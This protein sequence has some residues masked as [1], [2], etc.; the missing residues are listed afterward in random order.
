MN[1]TQDPNNSTPEAQPSWLA[2]LLTDKDRFRSWIASA[3]G[4]AAQPVSSD[5]R[6][7]LTD[8]G[9]QLLEGLALPADESADTYPAVL[10]GAALYLERHGWIQGSYYDGT[11]GV[12]TPPACSVG[13]IGMVCYGG[14]VDAPAQM[15]GH[16]GWVDFEQAIA[17]LDGFLLAEAG[18]QA[19]DF[20]DARGRTLDEVTHALRQAASTPSEQ[21]QAALAAQ[22]GNGSHEPGTD[23][24][25]KECLRACCCG[26]AVA[27]ADIYCVHCEREEQLDLMAGR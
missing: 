5:D 1:P 12:F 23:D 8:K 6:Y 26:T 4:T 2:G 21:V 10:R 18:C 14:P 7:D 27:G 25:C 20:N 22:H 13:A 19:Y 24:S 3:A 16:E 9:R 11:S 15:F 17:H